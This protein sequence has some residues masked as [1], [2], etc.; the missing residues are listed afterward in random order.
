MTKKIGVREL[1]R[2]IKILDEYD[3]I[4]IEDKKSKKSKGIFVSNK[5]ADEIKKLIEE[6]EKKEKERKLN[7][8][9]QFAGILEG[10]IPDVPYSQLR[11]MKREKYEE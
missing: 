11:A 3:L 4:E 1:A 2:N 7:R 10:E 5:Y 9:L 6:K 8:I